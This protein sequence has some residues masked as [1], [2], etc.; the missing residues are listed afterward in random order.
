MLGRSYSIAVDIDSVATAQTLLTL[1]LP[2]DRI[3]LLKRIYV[4]ARGQP[5]AEQLS[6]GVYHVTT[7]GTPSVAQDNLAGGNHNLVVQRNDPGDAATAAEI[8]A[9]FS[10]EPTSLNSDPISQ[11]GVQ[12]MAGFEFVPDSLDEVVVGPSQ[13]VAVKLMAAPNASHNLTVGLEFSEIG[14]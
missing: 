4:T 2:S 14:T 3:A 6:I 13:S 10:S 9:E 7:L 5:S 1:T 12:N 8:R 11:R